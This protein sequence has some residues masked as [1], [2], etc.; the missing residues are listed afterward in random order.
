[1]STEYNVGTHRQDIFFFSTV[2]EVILGQNI[3]KEI[4]SEYKISTN[5]YHI[6]RINRIGRKIINV[7]DREEIN[8]Y[9][10]VIEKEDEMNAFAIPGGYVYIF[11]EL[12]EILNDDELAYVL[13]HEVGHIVSR[14]LVKR[15]QAAMGYNLLMIAA[16]QAPAGPEFVSGL[17]F[18][19]TQIFLGY[20]RE[21]E[22]NADEL[23]IKYCKL[24]GFD[25]KAGITSLDKI[26]EE[27]KKTIR[28]LS[29]FRT[30]PYTAQRIRHI[31]EVLYLP[32]S[33][34][35]YMNL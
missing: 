24:A 3:A 33:P 14:H 25:P 6:E 11:E 35:D 23:A 19:L 34:E 1:M 26:Y 30:H 18:A 12:F 10:Y 4:A 17:S 22:L 31:K 27:D 5:P 20:S 21:D 15:L 2:K 9:F 7:C 29:Y 28:P 8:Y 16:S 32:L 13:A